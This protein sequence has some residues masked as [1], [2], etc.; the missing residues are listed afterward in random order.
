MNTFFRTIHLYLALAAGLVIAVV[1]F[2]GATL[3]FEKEMQAVIY[4]ER[5]SIETPGTTRVS[6]EM[7]STHLK[8]VAP[9]AN[10]T[11]V[12]VYGDPMRTVEISY[13][14]GKSETKGGNG[15][16]AFMHPVTGEVIARS[17]S[18]APF[19]LTMFSLH[20]WLLA[21]DTGK[22]IVG[23]STLIFLVILITGIILWWPRNWAIL[24]QRLKLKLRSGW[25]RANHD[26]H[27]V[28]G[29]YTAIFLFACAFTGLAWSFN[30]FNDGIYWVTGS[31]KPLPP[32]HSDTTGSRTAITLSQALSAAHTLMP[33]AESYA[34][35]AARRADDPVRVTVMPIDAVHER[36]SNQV[37]IDQYSGK[38]LDVRRYE[39]QNLG[40]QVR[41]TFYPIHVGSIGGVAGRIIACLS[42][43]AGFTF[44]IT[45]TI[46]WINRL[47]KKKKRRATPQPEPTIE[48][49]LIEA[50]AAV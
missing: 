24:K 36:A 10:I 26:L 6:L 14:E 1:C 34:V 31:A 5:Y 28:V 7:M 21:G 15:L 42:C 11:G 23:V 43:I 13:E 35:S 32:P 19:F 2:T 29:F 25:K 41:S 46:L 37:F 12:K 45:G 30:W 49:E 39:D 47:R 33:H 16:V 17:T 22:V 38:V 44:P 50:E 4:P 27:I 8:D 48:P 3:V 20:R 9:K 18:K 40:Q